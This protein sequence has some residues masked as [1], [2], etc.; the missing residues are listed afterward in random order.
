M[1]KQKITKTHSIMNK[2]LTKIYV[3]SENKNK[4]QLKC[5]QKL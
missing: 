5:Q 3:K 2:T 1:D 4:I